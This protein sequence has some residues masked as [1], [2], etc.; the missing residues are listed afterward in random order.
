MSFNGKIIKRKEGRRV[1]YGSDSKRIKES[2][3]MVAATY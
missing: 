1:N 3:E 2:A